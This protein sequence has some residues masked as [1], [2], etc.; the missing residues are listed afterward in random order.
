MKNKIAFG[1]LSGVGVLLFGC[2][3]YTA[4]TREETLEVVKGS[5]KERGIAKL[6]RLNQSE[7]QVACSEASLTGKDLPQEARTRLERQAL[8][9]VKYPS[10]GQYLGDFKQGERIAQTGVGMQWS[11]SETTV[12]GGNCYACHEISPQE[13]A[14][15]NIGPSLKGYRKLRG[16]SPAVI[17]YTWG[18]LWNSHAYNACSQMPRYGDANILTT[19]QLKD[20]MALLLDPNS[21]VNK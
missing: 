14:Y 5:F 15:G 18:K 4:P 13:I 12:A 7:L 1:A 8:G 2:A 10:D 20:L 3:V 17:T 11:D 6:D 16:A 21:P 19:A 9:T